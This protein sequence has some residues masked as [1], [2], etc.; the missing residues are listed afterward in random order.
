MLTSEFSH[1]L[2][3]LAAIDGRY[4][5]HVAVLRPFLSEYGLIHQRVV[6]E[7]A[8][9]KTLAASEQI[10]D[11]PKFSKQEQAFLTQ[12]TESFNTNDA[13]AIKRIEQET[14]HDVK[15]VEYYLK[16][17]LEQHDTLKTIT[18]FIHF[19]CTSE[20]INNLAYALM[21]K[22]SRDTLLPIM[23]QL[24]QKFLNLGEQY[25]NQPM[26]ARTHGQPASPTTVGKEFAN[27]AARLE[28]QYT[29]FEQL[30]ILGKFNGAVGNYNAHLAA[31]PKVN[32]E[33]LTSTLI[34][35]LGLHCNTLT[36]QIEPHDYIAEYCH[37]LIR[38]NTILIDLCRDMWGYIALN[39]F[40][41]NHNDCEVGSSTMPHKV[42]PID[43]E[44][45]EGNL[46]IA[47]AIAG[48][49]ATTLP[50]SRWQRDL[51]DSTTLRNLS[52]VIAHS[53]IAYQS[54]QRGMDKTELNTTVIMQDLENRWELLAE[55][56]QTVMRRYNQP[57]AYEQLK[58]L[59]RGQIVD[60]KSLH[61]LIEKSK[62]PTEA[63]Q[64]LLAL[65]PKQYIG[66]AAQQAK[67]K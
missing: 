47:N 29:Q 7:I 20:D 54:V 52:S 21:L 6:V 25:A 41:Q 8:W 2:F 64:M 48:H 58:Q 45:S 51:S 61:I 60:K 11:V 34:D 39:Y 53:L 33:K 32:W 24:I 15:A 49:L 10:N 59:T 44:N 5:R 26:L 36:T 18:E 67:K 43:F 30:K 17:K 19:A 27:V 23:Q 13:L 3:A 22:K 1:P 37:T 62:L 40:K 66:N 4:H 14:N 16:Q 31:Y 56:I 63:K 46:G 55:A 57:N 9:L 35:T 38:F 12:L 28:Q 65:T 42:N 50:I